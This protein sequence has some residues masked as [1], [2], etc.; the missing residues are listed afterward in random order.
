MAG[1]AHAAMVH[2]PLPLA[3]SHPCATPVSRGPRA[4]R[5]DA[6]GSSLPIPS[7][8]Q[9]AAIEQWEC[10]QTQPQSC[11]TAIGSQLAS[12]SRSVSLAI[13]QGESRLSTSSTCPAPVS[14]GP[15]SGRGDAEAMGAAVAAS[16]S[17]TGQCSVGTAGD[18]LLSPLRSLVAAGGQ[19]AG[20]QSAPPRAPVISRGPR[21]G[22]LPRLAK[23]GPRRL[24]RCV[25]AR[26]GRRAPLWP[27]PPTSVERAGRASSFAQRLILCSCSC[28][29]TGA[30]QSVCNPSSLP[31]GLTGGRQRL[32]SRAGLCGVR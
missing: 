32:G 29:S 14:R 2:P 30:F 17:P 18:V 22:L 20:P 3:T 21:A 7:R 8:S 19:C 31:R 23:A 27:S 11:I 25:Q 24:P 28:K 12:S 1:S 4:G 16:A 10:D 9:L 26:G 13:V 15:R 5:G 6:A